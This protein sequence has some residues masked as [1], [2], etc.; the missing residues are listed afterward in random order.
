MVTLEC[1]A[2]GIAG[3]LEVEGIGQFPTAGTMV[4]T[5]VIARDGACHGQELF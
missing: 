5:E 4:E 1:C 3:Y 2:E